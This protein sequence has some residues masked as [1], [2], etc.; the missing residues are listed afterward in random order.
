VFSWIIVGQKA[1]SY[2]WL[3]KICLYYYVLPDAHQGI[4]F[5]AG[6]C[7]WLHA[8]L[9]R[10]MKG[11]VGVHG[12]FKARQGELHPKITIKINSRNLRCWV[13]NLELN[14]EASLELFLQ[15]NWEHRS[16]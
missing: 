4:D 1:S 11:W 8:C 3:L 6:P 10:M 14:M 12:K 5:G 2:A 7:A 9:P 15:L 16:P 13:V